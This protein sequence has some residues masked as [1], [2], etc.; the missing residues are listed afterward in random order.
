MT[1]KLC[2]LKNA[3]KNKKRLRFSDDQTVNMGRLTHRVNNI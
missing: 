3:N 2:D 1:K